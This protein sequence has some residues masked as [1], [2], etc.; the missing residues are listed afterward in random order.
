MESEA[1]EHG[2]T[3]HIQTRRV[4]DT[5]T[6]TT[7]VQIMHSMTPSTCKGKEMVRQILNSAIAQLQKNHHITGHTLPHKQT[8]NLRQSI[9]LPASCPLIFSQRI[10][11]VILPHGRVPAAPQ[12]APKNA[13]ATIRIRVIVITVVGHTHET[14]NGV[15]N[16]P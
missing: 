15:L 5:P 8:K 2:R 12:T 16:S 11:I 3:K 14:R 10:P 7:A 13:A 9:H 1:V 6:Q 4:H